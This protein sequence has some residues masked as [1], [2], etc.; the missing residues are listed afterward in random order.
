MSEKNMSL[1]SQNEIDALISFLNYNKNNN[2]ISGDILSQNSINKLIELVKSIPSL[3]KNVLLN[4]AAIKADASSFLADKKDI[5]GYELTFKIDEN[6]QVILFACNVKTDDIIKVSPQMITFSNSDNYPKTWGTCI[7]PATFCFIAR[8]LK[9]G[10]SDETLA[11]IS[12]LFA[13]KM[14]GSADAVVPAFY[15]S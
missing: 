4:T 12:S 10:Y 7:S 5:N 6:K 14:Y 3:D 13:E 15:L 9:L 2:P 1:L 8:L 11:N